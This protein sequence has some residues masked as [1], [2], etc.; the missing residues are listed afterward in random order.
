[1]LWNHPGTKRYFLRPGEKLIA[2]GHKN[3]G[4]HRSEVIHIPQHVVKEL[5]PGKYPYRLDI[6]FSRT[7]VV[8]LPEDI[9]NWLVSKFDN[10]YK[11]NGQADAN[12]EPPIKDN[13]P[14]KPRPPEPLNEISWKELTEIAKKYKVFKVGIKREK[15]IELIH[16]ATNDNRA[17]S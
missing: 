10:V 3:A 9:A 4:V 12:N 8:M 15:L 6:R 13:T 2:I 1:M 17:G 5:R 16:E 7:K 11:V 14:H